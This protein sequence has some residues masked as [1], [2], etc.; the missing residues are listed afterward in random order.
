MSNFETKINISY[1]ES[2]KILKDLKI[3]PKAEEKIFFG[4]ALNR[5]LA[6]D[7]VA[8]NH[9]PCSPTS[10]MDGYAFNFQDLSKLTSDGLKI[11]GINKAGEIEQLECKA[12][13]CIKTFTGSRIPKNC[14]TLVLSEYVLEEKGNI[15]LLPSSPIPSPN[16][17]I[18]QIGENY[19]KG[20][21]LIHRGSKITPFEIGLLADLNCV[22]VQVF[23]LPKIAILSGGDEI[24][25]VGEAERENTIRS[26]NNHLLRAIAMSWGVEASIFP[27]LR[28]DK[29]SIRDQIH[30]ALQSC[31]ILVTTGGASHGDFDFVQ[32]V[33]QEVCQMHFK[34][35]R[36]KP[37]KP[38]G[39]GVYQ[40]KTFVF[41]LP[42][43]PNSCA[44]SFMLFVRIIVQK[45]LC[46]ANQ[47]TPFLNAKLIDPI[48]K[49][50]DRAEFRICDIKI[51]QGEIQVGF[52]NKKT[53]QSSIINNFC[54]QSALIYLKEGKS[55]LKAKDAVKV[56]SLEHLLN[57]SN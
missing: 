1:E 44:V 49:S 34:G 11:A 41:G 24:I 19:K 35:I 54:N 38:V 18:R 31:D 42:G 27:L 3:K 20:E 29:R 15:T 51:E 53:F 55:S 8:Q 5:V 57:L 48:E 30:N 56:I 13:E 33:L 17:W 12:G 23:A 50:D 36:M 39:F 16:Q 26:V 9:M 32:E 4:N 40:D 47:P 37:G 2:L 43:F 28:D 22:F 52:W 14:D 7:I 46:I 21:I 45:M 25:E 10:A 6:Q